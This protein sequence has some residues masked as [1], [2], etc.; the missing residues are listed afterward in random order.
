MK[1]ILIFEDHCGLMSFSSSITSVLIG[2]IS[3]IR[4]LA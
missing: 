2:L 3:E 4:E 1:Y